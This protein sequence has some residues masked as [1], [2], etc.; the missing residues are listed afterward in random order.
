MLNGL[1][2]ENFKAFGGRRIIPIR[3]ITLIFGPNSAGKSAILQSLLLLKQTL[4]DVET[5]DVAVRLKG[6]LVDLG[7]FREMIFRHEIDRTCEITPLL[8][9]DLGYAN[10]R[11]TIAGMQQVLSGWRES[12]FGLGLK[13]RQAAHPGPTVLGS[14]PLY[15]GDP[16]DQVADLVS[17]HKAIENLMDG[18]TQEPMNESAPANALRF[19][20]PILN[21]RHGVWN[22]LYAAFSTE[23]LPRFVRMLEEDTPYGHDFEQFYL[24]VLG[25]DRRQDADFG[26]SE[27]A[28]YRAY[29]FN[30]YCRDLEVDAAFRWLFA[31]RFLVEDGTGT[32]PLAFDGTVEH[33]STFEATEYERKRRDLLR[34]LLYDRDASHMPSLADLALEMSAALRQMLEGLVYLGPL[35]DYPERHYLFGGSNPA[36]VGVSGRMVAEVLFGR[37]DLLQRTNETLKQFNIGYKLNVQRLRDDVGEEGDVYSLRLVDIGNGVRV[38]L[39]DVGFGISQ[40][41]PV[42]VQSFL[43]ENSTILIEQP[44]LH[45]HPRL[46]AELG[47]VFIQSALGGSGNTFVLE[48]HSEHLVLR[49]MRRLRDTSRGTLPDGMPEL[50]PSDVSV[51]YIQPTPEGSIPLVMDIDEEGDLLSAW[52]NG[53]FEEGFHERFS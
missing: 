21:R 31:R 49:I 27:L 10:P 22:A 3:P 38:S 6:S 11:P 19:V 41:L 23:E 16:T 24:E 39:R 13:L 29:D 30:A 18:T 48:T 8:T 26:A 45:L 47:D 1:V 17:L 25:L 35:R 28:K 12:S 50:R 32:G 42:L 7:S 33:P 51:I 4:S 14:L 34:F 36:N 43:A 20:A 44:E 46:Q 5:G 9:P 15:F 37:N 53:F 2:L 40:V 52:P